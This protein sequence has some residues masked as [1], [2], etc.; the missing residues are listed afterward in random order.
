ME[1]N[2]DKKKTS[3][4]RN[5]IYNTLYK[6]LTMITP[7]ITAPFL[8]R[9]IGKDNVGIFSY[10]YAIAY[11]FSLVA[12]LGLINY[13]S[14]SI[15]RVRDDETRLAETFS[16]IYYL[17]VITSVIATIAYYC[18]VRLFTN[19]Y[20]TIFLLN[21]IYVFSIAFDIDWL[22]YGTENF[23]SISLR[24][25]FI[26]IATVIAIIL[27]VKT[28]NGLL[29]YVIIMIVSD[30]LKF[31]AIWLGFG[32]TT[33]F[34]KV[35]F[36]EIFRH[37]K[38]CAILFIPVIATSVYRSMDKIMLGALSDMGQTGLYEYSEKIVYMLLGFVTSLEVVMMPRI[39]NMLEKGNKDAAL[40]S[41]GH[42]MT[43]VIALTSAMA[44][45]I[46]G[47]TSRFI[48]LFYGEEFLGCIELLP[49]LAM[50]LILIGIANVVR[51]QYIMPKG[52]DIIYVISTIIGAVVNLVVNWICI[53]L[54]GAKGAVI[55][56]IFAELSVAVYLLFVVRK[57]L[58]LLEYLKNGFVFPIIG[59]IM[60]VAVHFIGTAIENV[61]VSLIVQV[62]A[63]ILLF[64]LLSGLYL[65]RFQPELFATI[66]RPFRKIARRFKK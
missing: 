23:K 2:T 57:E 37:L 36:R 43:F 5:Y 62:T 30:V 42:S 6:V 17:Q 7:L 28:E 33:K 65:K 45:G 10:T 47:I 34:V 20:T 61:V 60:A 48:P 3:V 11:N 15:A 56:T 8:A 21:G 53:P 41:I 54:L 39:S 13:G 29:T 38:P 64:G 12:K 24:N 63:G 66:M 55:G 19:D 14:R 9:V 51:T 59:L 16:Q 31:A 27:F 40:K 49:P 25:A 35:A 52:R 18:F 22:F 44:F 4:K 26:K 58:P 46:S 1:Q 32:K 50:T